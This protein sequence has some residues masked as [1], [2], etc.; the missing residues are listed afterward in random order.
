MKHIS[1]STIKRRF[2]IL[3]FILVTVATGQS[4]VLIMSNLSLA[5]HAEQLSVTEIPLLNKSHEL[6]LAV[7]QVQQW[8]TDISATRGLDGLDDGF[9]EA[10]TNAEEFKKLIEEMA[11]LDSQYAKEYRAMLPTF[12]S[13]YDVGRTMARAYIESGPAGGNQ[14][15]S[16]FDEVA[17]N[18]STAVDDMLQ[19]IA[20]RSYQ[21][22]LKQKHETETMQSTM[23]IGAVI[24]FLGI[25]MLYLIISRALSRF[26]HVITSLQR[27]ANG[28]LVSPVISSGNDELTELTHY[29]DEMRKRFLTIAHDI[30]SAANNLT[31]T[32]DQMAI[33]AAQSTQNVQKQHSETDQVATAMNEM[34]ST[35]KEVGVNT[36]RAAE[37]ALDANSETLSGKSI[38]DQALTEISALANQLES[39]SG[40]VKSLEHDSESITA[41]LDVIKG[42][43]EQTNLLALNAA[44]EAARAGEH[45]RG[46]A[47]VADEVRTL[48]SRTQQS[49]EEIQQMIESLQSGSREA[50][51][52]MQKS[53]EGAQTVVE[54]AAKIGDSLT[55]ISSAVAKISDMNTQ[56]AAAAAEQGAVSE[57]INRNIVHIN[58]M[59]NNATEYSAQSTCASKNMAGLAVKLQTAVSHFKLS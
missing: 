51:D 46:F 9:A 53:Q 42:I 41:I 52:V 29:L 33:M 22:L 55:V 30:A 57:E 3:A 18:I 35:I 45:G 26:P 49:T 54:R 12:Q 2:S 39:A 4:I 40:V 11:R 14:L 1:K 58:E 47:V 7:V 13:Y 31:S 50:V 20:D 6:K 8:L 28:D 21:A 15:M 10:E 19:R 16:N 25:L 32:S 36:S 48:A 38:V 56:I 44:I 24:L 43:A 37:T 5:D 34:T 27:L 17:A 59:A 23:I